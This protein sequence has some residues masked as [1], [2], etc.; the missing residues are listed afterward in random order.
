MYIVRD[1]VDMHIVMCIIMNAHMYIVILIVTQITPHKI[2][3]LNRE[4]VD[5]TSM[6]IHTPLTK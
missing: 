6:S 2:H 5:G 1:S 3:H 4:I